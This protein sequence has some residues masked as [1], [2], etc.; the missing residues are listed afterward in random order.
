MHVDILQVELPR[1]IPLVYKLHPDTLKPIKPAATSAKRHDRMTGYP[2]CPVAMYL[3]SLRMLLHLATSVISFVLSLYV[4]YITQ[5]I[6]LNSLH[7][8]RYQ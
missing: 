1:A 3:P 5:L 8:L 4:E 6:T 7:I 2:P